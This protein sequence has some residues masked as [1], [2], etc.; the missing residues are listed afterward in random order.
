M[1]GGNRVN[2]WQEEGKG[3]GVR[4]AWGTG[5]CCG[6]RSWG[7]E[8]DGAGRG[9]CGW[10]GWEGRQQVLRADLLSLLSLQPWSPLP[11][12]ASTLRIPPP[13]SGR[14]SVSWRR[15]PYSTRWTSAAAGPWL[16]AGS[17]SSPSG[18]LGQ[19]FWQRPACSA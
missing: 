8:E 12:S 9:Q 19:P 18:S 6:Q 15:R 5:V 4:G 1:G 14:H 11:A 10:A 3:S 2:Q 16:W 7:R 17:V 13:P